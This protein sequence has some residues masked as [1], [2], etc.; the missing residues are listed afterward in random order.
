MIESYVL[1]WIQ[2]WTEKLDDIVFKY[3][4]EMA[5]EVVILFTPKK[6]FIQVA[7]IVVKI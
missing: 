6:R 7:N 4:F 3:K 5:S 2:T 1:V